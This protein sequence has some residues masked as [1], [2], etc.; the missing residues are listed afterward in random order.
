MKRR[1]V[2]KRRNRHLRADSASLK[3]MLRHKGYKGNIFDHPE[4]AREMVK[5][6]RAIDLLPPFHAKPHR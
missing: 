3:A 2:I 6:E 5:F 4:V 1:T